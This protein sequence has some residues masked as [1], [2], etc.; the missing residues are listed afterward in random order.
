[1]ATATKKSHWNWQFT[2]VHIHL[3]RRFVAEA[4]SFLLCVGI[5]VVASFSPTKKSSCCDKIMATANK[6]CTKR[7]WRIHTAITWNKRTIFRNKMEFIRSSRLITTTALA[8]I[9]VPHVYFYFLWRR[10][11][12][13]NKTMKLI[14]FAEQMRLRCEGDRRQYRWDRQQQ[15]ALRIKRNKITIKWDIVPEICEWARVLTK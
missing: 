11:T 9:G 1:M 10:C 2:L 12:N 15:R 13:C 5:I 3:R 4:N 14:R 7:C 8:S 6:R